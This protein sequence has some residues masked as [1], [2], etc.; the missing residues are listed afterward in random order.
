MKKID[1]ETQKLYFRIFDFL[2]VPLIILVIFIHMKNPYQE[3]L[4]TDFPLLSGEGIL[5]LTVYS[6]KLCIGAVAVPTFF[7]I[8]GYLFFRDIE[9]WDWSL[10]RKKMKSRIWTLIIP[11]IIWILLVYALHIAKMTFDCIHN[12]ESIQSV[13]SFIIDK[14]FTIFYDYKAEFP[15]I[16]P[17]WYLRNLIGLSICTPL[18]YLFISRLKFYG[19]LLLMIFYASGIYPIKYMVIGSTISF[20]MGAYLALNRID[21]INILAKWKKILIPAYIVCLILEIFKCPGYKLTEPFFLYIS[22]AAVLCIA[23]SLVK[24]HGMR[25]S[26]I[27]TSACFFAY[28]LHDV[29]FPGRALNSKIYTLLQNIIPGD[30][31]C[32]Q[33][34]CYLITPFLNFATCVLI[35]L[36]LNRICPRLAGLLSGTRYKISNNN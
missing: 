23:H 17:L 22:I 16:V 24:N 4:E 19:L 35:L 15:Y 3:V 6:F 18:I 26:H 7:F 20:S 9:K 30:T 2:R 28:A 29:H 34:F 36:V 10:Y 32:E 21:F 5:N 31:Y 12:G 13:V 33:I 1:A 14:H 25:F 27:L 11:Y 8:S